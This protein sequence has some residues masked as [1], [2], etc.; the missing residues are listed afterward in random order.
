MKNENNS[1]NIETI[2]T[3]IMKKFLILCLLV[4]SSYLFIKYK[5]KI[6]S[7]DKEKFLSKDDLQNIGDDFYDF[8]CSDWIKNHPLP[9]EYSRFASFDAITLNVQEQLKELLDNFNPKNDLESKMKIVYD[10]IKNED[11]RNNEKHQPLIPI[12]KKIKDIESKNDIYDF[13]FKILINIRM[14]FFTIDLGEDFLDSN[15]YLLYIKQPYLSLRDKD[16]YIKDDEYSQK[17]LNEYKKH[18]INV[19]NLIGYNNEKSESIMNNIIE[20]ETNIAKISKSRVELRDIKANYHKYE[21]SKFLNE[22]KSN[23]NWQKYFDDLGFKDLDVLSVN[24]V[25]YLHNIIDYLDNLSIDKCKDFFEWLI[26]DRFC[27]FCGKELFDEN[28]NFYYRIMD[29]QKEPK[30]KWKRDLAT[31]QGIFSEGIGKMYVEKYFPESHKKAMENLV[32]QLKLAFYKR[33]D[34]Q[35]WMSDETKQKAKKKLDTFRVKIGYP[36]KWEQYE[37]FPSV[38]EKDNIIDVLMNY[39]KW[40][41]QKE[42]KEKYKKE[43]DREKW[44]MPPQMV[45]AY[46][47]P[48]TNEICFPAAILQKPFFDINASDAQ[49]YGAIGT[50]IAHE[51]THGFDD[52]GRNFDEKGNMVDWWTPDDDKKFKEKANILIN[53]FDGLETLP[54]VKVNGKLT[55]SENLADHGGVNIAYHAYKN[56]CKNDDN[57]KEFFYSYARIW[58]ENSTDEY[59]KEQVLKDPHS[60]GKLRVNGILPH[61]NAWY[62]IFK[63]NKKHKLFIPENERIDIW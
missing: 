44:L 22:F 58:A 16:Y 24:Q 54:G 32:N 7:N 35:D 40:Y 57:D 34:V 19:F 4:S 37:N 63:I 27:N 3:T 8:V 30:A 14:P 46:Y 50:V 20:I 33:I 59:K 61:I 60:P 62:K 28:F 5:N 1:I 11:K 17:I 9:N 31:L 12:L 56:V 25:E 52:Q 21:Y 45:N 10:I 48:C 41:F 47:N 6:M 53:Y 43:V 15:H 55:I 49:N 29:G 18:I 51:M 39:S 26:I 42:M 13:L 23:I 38:N 36:N 2:I